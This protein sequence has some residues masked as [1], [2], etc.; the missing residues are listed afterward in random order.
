MNKDMLREAI[1]YISDECSQYKNCEECKF[2]NKYDWN[3][4]YFGSP[5]MNWDIEEILNRCEVKR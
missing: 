1:E 2:Y 4:C 3:E 5:P